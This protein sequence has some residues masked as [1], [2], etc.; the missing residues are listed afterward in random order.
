MKILVTLPQYETEGKE[1]LVF[2]TFFTPA[3]KERLEKLGDVKY[4]TLTRQFTDDELKT[5]LSDVDIVFAGWG[6]HAYSKEILDCAPKLKLI[7][8]TGGSIVPLM[9]DDGE[10]EKRGIQIHSGNKIFAL[11]VAEGA[12]CYM[13]VAQRR[14]TEIVGEVI[15]EGWLLERRH[16]EGLFYKKIGIVGFGMI[17]EE[18]IKLLKPYSPEIYVYSSH[19][20]Q[21][22]ADELGVKIA[23]LDELFEECDIISIH[24]GLNAKNFHLVD[25]RLLKKMKDGALIVNTAR[26][27]IIDEAAMTRELKTGRIRAIL[28]VFEIEPVPLDSELRGLNNVIIVPHQGGPTLDMR[29]YVTKGLLDDVEKYLNG[30]DSYE[31]RISYEYGKRMTNEWLVIGGRK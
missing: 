4:N 13:M 27:A 7:A 16:T 24:S 23:G 20:K 14:L 29:E 6:T 8:Y 12:V 31:H 30:V 1:S 10:L 11:S 9:A 22:K 28:D 15:N 17:A 19:L 18:T 3:M 25:E 2:K 21:E 5:E 26:G